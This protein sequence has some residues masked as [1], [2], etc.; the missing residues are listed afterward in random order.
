MIS[1]REDSSASQ[2]W[3]GPSEHRAHVAR[4]G[5]TSPPAPSH[6]RDCPA[7]RGRGGRPVGEVA[8][9]PRGHRG[10]ELLL[11]PGGVG[12]DCVAG[13]PAIEG[14]AQRSRG[15]AA[16]GAAAARQD[17]DKRA[18]TIYR[19]LPAG[20]KEAEDYFLLGRA[21]I[22]S[23]EVDSAY[24]AYQASLER[25]PN[26]PETLAALAAFYVGTDRIDA[27]AEVAERL[28]QQPASEARARVILGR[29]RAEV[30]DHA[31]AARALRRGLEL[32][33]QG[34]AVA[35]LPVDSIRKLLIAS[36]L[37]SGRPA[38]ARA[39]LDTLL[40]ADPDPEG[41]WLLSRCFIQEGHWDRAAEV[42]RRSPSYRPEHPL[43]PEPAPYVGEARCAACHREQYDAVLASRHASTFARAGELGSLALPRDAMPDPGNPRVMHRLRREGDAAG[44]RDPGGR[45][46]LA[47]GR[48][49]CVRIPR[50]FHY[51]RRPGRP[52]PI[53]DG[54]DVLLPIPGRAWAGTS[55]PAFRACR[56]MG[57]NIWARRCPRA[58]GCVDA[59][60]VTR[61][62]PTRS[63]MRR[64]R[65]PRTGRSAA[66]GVMGPAAT[67]SRPWRLGSRTWRSSA[68]ARRR[69]PRPISSARSAT[70]PSNPGASTLPRTDLVWLRFQSLTL[71]WSRCYT[72]SD[73]M[74]GCV[75]CH[76]PHR[77][78]ETS[79]G[80]ER[81]QMPRVPPRSADVE[82]RRVRRRLRR[83][84][85]G[86]IPHG[87]GRHRRRP[88][89]DVRSIR[90]AAASVATCRASGCSPPI[91]SRQI[92]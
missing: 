76:D 50:P 89:P 41:S 46:G 91:P 53:R 58:T 19:R 92:T 75:T 62:M 14:S 8:V 60:P 11:L 18:I 3:S 57:K 82:P 39:A 56:P 24:E 2:A 65:S 26:H 33:P 66:S 55:P 29:I 88:G 15:P 81:G 37:R 44:R 77:N 27:A 90:I 52:A 28:A 38:E 68:P 1:N 83:R 34:R 69:R 86:R 54:P 47:R 40:G 45:A 59:S 21:L 36:L 25:D 9:L 4:G 20:R 6:G 49:L 23:G 64:A 71:P 10:S 84:A 22:R 72:E 70:G 42:L 67:T 13:P 79:V 16:R 7:D 48:R 74:L 80:P 17:Q 5:G 12:P 87:T 61:P 51:L 85:V 32:D 31:G 73:G 78:A 30:Q 63:C 35:P 43:E